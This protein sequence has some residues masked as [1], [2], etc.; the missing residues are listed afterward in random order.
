MPNVFVTA[1]C[2]NACA[3]CFARSKM[4]HYRSQGIEEMD[5]KDFTTV[6]Q[7]LRK[8]GF[9][10]YRVARWRTNHTGGAGNEG[11]EPLTKP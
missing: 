11:G 10:E 4:E 3:W 1:S 5:W 6:V 9:E 7:F 8:V 2:Q